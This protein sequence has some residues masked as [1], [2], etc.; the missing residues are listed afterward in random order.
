M[1]EEKKKIK[2][3]QPQ[4]G[5]QELFVRS[6]VD[7]VIFGGTLG[8]G[9]S[10]GAILANA[11][12]SLDSKYRAAFFRKT[13]KELKG[14][15]SITDDFK[16][17]FGDSITIKM[18]ENPRIT[19][20]NSGAFIDCH[21]LLD[22]TPQKI[23]E[24]FK[25]MQ[26]DA[27]FFEE[28]TG[29]EFFTW[30]YIA[31]RVRGKSGWSGKVRATTNPSK[32]HW[33]RKLLDWYIGP[34]GLVPP[35]KSGVVR[36][37][38]LDGTSV[39]DYVWGDSKEEVYLKCKPSIDRKIAKMGGVA[40][41]D[42]FIKS[43]TFILGNLA[44]NSALLN[45]NPD[46]VGNVSGSVGEALLLGNWNSDLEVLSEQLI[47]PSLARKIIDN[48]EQR[49]NVKYVV[50]DVADTGTDNTMIFVFDGFHC[51]DFK[52]LQKSTPRV[53]CNWMQAMAA[54]HNIPDNHII[55]DGTRAAYVLDYIPNAI[56]YI[57]A[58]APRGKYRREFK[59]RKDESYMRLVEAING[60]RI[61]IAPEVANAIYEHQKLKPIS[62][63]TEFVDECECVYFNE[64]PDGKKRLPTKKEMNATLGSG[65]SM[66]VLDV[67]SMLMSAYDQYE[68]GCELERRNAYETSEKNE[69]DTFSVYDDSFWC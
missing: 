27:A 25:G 68:Y 59:L 53:N 35:E 20:R 63:L 44:E 26:I 4:A 58:Y 41:Y 67:F 22:E 21:Q 56:C 40:T 54:K 13:L 37:V 48:D 50:A 34:D 42:N 51:I 39:E 1:A 62:I 60:R 5:G 65:R 61:S 28:L 9:K 11:E 33:V 15:G 66:D 43:F 24:T 64:M 55:Y 18:S 29:Y 16:E 6:N 52:I 14:A 10:F 19:F 30:N 46:Y 32:T 47:K 69:I 17:A 57:S 38:Y 36:Y 7:I 12:P 8:G 23:I 31:S 45:N 3:I 2:I 49:N